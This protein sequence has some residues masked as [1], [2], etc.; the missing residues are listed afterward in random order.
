MKLILL[1]KRTERSFY[2][3]INSE[4]RNELVESY[5]KLAKKTDM[6]I[7]IIIPEKNPM[8]AQIFITK[9]RD[10]NDLLENMLKEDFLVEY[11][12]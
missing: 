2:V 7:K 12:A 3:P 9:K 11:Y 10:T 5:K 1:R 4:K 8:S 6:N